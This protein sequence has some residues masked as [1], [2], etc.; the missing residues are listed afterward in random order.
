KL[1]WPVLSFRAIPGKGAEGTV[2][3]KNV[4]AVSPGYLREKQINPFDPHIEALSAQGKTVIYVLIDDALT[5]AIALADIV[6]SESKEAIARLKGMGIRCL[7]L[8]GDKQEV[9]DW[10]AKK[11]ALDE[12]IA[13]VLPDQ[14]V[15]KIREVKGRKLITAMTGDGVND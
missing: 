3:G 7:M 5:G 11:I 10:V 8:T 15:A 9:A 1:K 6:R 2:N 14:K 13:E 12:V 4:K